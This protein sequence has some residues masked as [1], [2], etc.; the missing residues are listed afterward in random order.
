MPGI[1][2]IIGKNNVKKN[3]SLLQ[4]M[5][6]CMLHEPFYTSGMYINEDHNLCVGWV[7]HEGSFTDCMPVWNE[8]KEICL[9]F[10]GENFTDKIRI[11]ELRT[12]GHQFD[13]NN[14]S[15]LIH[16]YEEMGLE[17]IE[18]LNGWF[19]GVLVDLRKKIIVLF[20]DRYGFGRICYHENASGF[21]F[22]SEA[23]ALLKV[24]PELRQLSFT[25]LGETFSCGCVLQNRTIFPN[26]SLLPGGS[27]W[28]FNGSHS[29][30][31]GSY[32]NYKSWEQQPALNGSE[33]YDKLKET[34]VRILPRYFH[35]HQKTAISLTGGVDSRMVM[36]WAKNPPG[37]LPCYTFGGT[38]RECTD[39]IIARKVATLCKQPH[40]VIPVDK[41]FLSQF[42]DLAE[43]TVYLSDGTMDV[44]GSTD[45]F[46]N[47]MA[48]DIAPVRLTGNYGGEIL[49]SL[50]AFK[51]VRLFD[52]IYDQD[53]RQVV[54]TARQTYRNEFND[55]TLSFIAFKQV[56]WHHYSRMAL[57]MTQLT[58]RSPYLDNDLVEIIYRAPADLAT[59]MDISLRLIADGNPIL[60]KIG[61]D[62]AVLFAPIPVITK[63]NHLYKQ[64]TFKAEYAYD[65]GM[66]QWLAQIDRLLSPLH[67]ERLFL[68]RHKFFHFRV[69][70]RDKLAEYLKDILLDS[71]T[72]SRPYFNSR[73]L[74]E[75]VRD[76]IEGRRNYTSEIHRI[77]TSELIQRQLIEMQ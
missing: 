3:A 17:F 23:K 55:R 51:P 28:I 16:L 58:I 76:H 43:K 71:R 34:F 46:V 13:S 42:P 44:S 38:Y 35:S 27:R 31:R 14:A 40:Q 69:W 19:N 29:I 75:I 5:I 65:Y 26:I 18:K 25:S 36:A 48:R 6:R 37:S 45:L 68:G 9:V 2:G 15:Y 60:S 30:N 12:L 72:L 63:I 50:V 49:R 21:Y 77:L 54:Q 7:N 67:P 10:H 8:T 33:Y 64:F 32:F 73:R 11:D 59:S 4:Q 52:E 53:F 61:T 41:D 56:P 62:R 47:R 39:V 24:L 20:N 1:V 70:Y 57:E 74:Q 66:P 22:A